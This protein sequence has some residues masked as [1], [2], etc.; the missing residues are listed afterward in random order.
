MVLVLTEGSL[1]DPDQ[2]LNRST[3]ICQFD[4]DNH[5]YLHFCLYLYVF[6]F[7]CVFVCC[8][9]MLCVFVFVCVCVLY[10]YLYA[11]QFC[12]TYPMCHDPAAP[13]VVA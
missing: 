3:H 10:L 4:D 8:I 5:F 6:V 2:A 9:C 12:P 7:V 13:V 11:V 1:F